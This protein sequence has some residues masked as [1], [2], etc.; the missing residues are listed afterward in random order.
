MPKTILITGKRNIESLSGKKDKKRVQ[1]KEWSK[2]DILNDEKK[3]SRNIK[4]IIF[5]TG[6]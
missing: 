2:I 6:I 1:S 5:R 4:S 3:T